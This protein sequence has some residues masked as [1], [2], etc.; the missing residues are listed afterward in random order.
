MSPEVMPSRMDS[1]QG[2]VSEGSP[3][4]GVPQY[5]DAKEQGFS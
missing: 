5:P 1:G 4:T 3:E 2:T